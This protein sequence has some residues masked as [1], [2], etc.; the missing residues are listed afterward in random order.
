MTLQRSAKLINCYFLT[1][2]SVPSAVTSDTQ[3]PEMLPPPHPPRRLF[4][5]ADQHGHRHFPQGQPTRTQQTR[6][7]CR[8][9]GY[10]LSGLRREV[11]GARRGRRWRPGPRTAPCTAQHPLVAR[12][13]PAAAARSFTRPQSERSCRDRAGSR[14]RI[15]LPQHPGRPGVTPGSGLK[16]HR[17]L[18]GRSMDEYPASAA[19][20]PAGRHSDVLRRLA[21]QLGISLS[22]F[23]DLQS[24]S[25]AKD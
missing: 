24:S 10:H 20:K 6:L 19:H 23:S 2:R 18:P 9:A 13:K 7:A 11:R 8:P 15:H 3:V 1:A 22:C 16:K 17:D 5:L 4:P 25:L 12:P 21:A 14:L